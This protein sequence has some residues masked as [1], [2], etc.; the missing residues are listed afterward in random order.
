MLL[1]GAAIAAVTAC[2]NA[3]E[4][5]ALEPATTTTEAAVEVEVTTTAPP[6][7]VPEPLNIYRFTTS[8]KVEERLLAHQRL[9]DH[10]LA[11]KPK[12]AAPWPSYDSEKPA[13]IAQKVK[14]LGFDPEAVISY[15]RENKARSSVIEA[16]EALSA[17]GAEEELVVA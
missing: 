5:V 1:V 4:E 13:T 2:S 14:D 3:P 9:D 8:D 16:L 10:I 12:V 15:E 7:T 6:A 11:E 17:D